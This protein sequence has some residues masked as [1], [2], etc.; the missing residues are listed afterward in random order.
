MPRFNR[1]TALWLAF[2][3][4]AAGASGPGCASNGGSRSASQ[5]RTERPAYVEAVA[6]RVVGGPIAREKLA[7]LGSSVRGAS[8]LNSTTPRFL[9]ELRQ[10]AD[11]QVIGRPEVLIGS[12]ES[13][14][15]RIGA[16]VSPEAAE[17]GFLS[18]VNTDVRLAIEPVPAARGRVGLRVTGSMLQ[19]TP[20]KPGGS[21][22]TAAYTRLRDFETDLDLAWNQ[23]ALV[24]GPALVEQSD[25]VWTGVVV[26]VTARQAPSTLASAGE[27]A[28]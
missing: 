15:V 17:M 28:E 5:A 7:A 1:G 6:V 11:V 10:V 26:L 12:G 18:G 24:A 14:T 22:D 21:A 19:F 16:P 20:D 27:D 23:P 4:V 25:G 9:D 2:G 13:R 8:A 3:V